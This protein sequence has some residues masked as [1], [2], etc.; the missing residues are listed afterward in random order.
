M[1]INEMNYWWRDLKT[2]TRGLDTR[3]RLLLAAYQ[4][5][6]LNG[7]QSSGLAQILERAGVT[8]GALYHH[9]KN[10]SEL[11]YAV[12]D[13]IIKDQ[14]LK[15]FM[16]PLETIENPIDGLIDLINGAGNNFTLQDI[17]LGCPLNNLAQEMAP[18]DEV[19]RLKLNAIYE[20]WIDF[21]KG[22]LLKGQ[23]DGF[24]QKDIDC[25]QM[26]IL[27]VATL[28]GC[29]SAAKISQ[30]LDSLQYCGAGLI[31]HLNFI[32]TETKAL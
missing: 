13:E 10:K 24:V 2:D 7:F 17:E 16:E 25:H 1:Q 23:Q 14:V 18:V 5:M 22:L 6:H 29:L 27:I 20:L 9:F 26:A 8:K 31:Q 15:G 12:I 19:F 11:G 3:E 21:M 32:R 28:E 30:N 4:E